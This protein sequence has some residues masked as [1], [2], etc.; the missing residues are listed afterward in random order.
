MIAFCFKR[1]FSGN[2]IALLSHK[3]SSNKRKG[4]SMKSLIQ[5]ARRE[6]EAKIISKEK[7]YSGLCSSCKTA[8]G[9]TYPRDL[10][11]PV[12]QC[13]EFEGYEPRI[14][15]TT[16]EKILLKTNAKFG[17]SNE[18]RDLSRYPG[19]CRNCE[20]RETCTFPKP[21]GAVWRCEEYR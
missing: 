2:K 7:E 12:L 8:S 13:E 17:S 14:V 15:K 3:N 11:R 6:K 4:G 5:P 10:R 19:L 1:I 21:E 9:C 20:D 18:R 16:V